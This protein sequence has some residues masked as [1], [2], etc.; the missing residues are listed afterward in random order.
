MEKEEVG[1]DSG[2]PGSRGAAKEEK[3]RL[4]MKQE[5]SLGPAGWLG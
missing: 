2:G 1:G 3:K 4:R 5:K